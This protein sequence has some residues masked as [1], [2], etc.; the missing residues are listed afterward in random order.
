MYIPVVWWLIAIN[1]IFYFI[2]QIPYWILS[3]NLTYQIIPSHRL[4]SIF[5]INSIS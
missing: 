5:H 1:H 2:D 4:N 3:F